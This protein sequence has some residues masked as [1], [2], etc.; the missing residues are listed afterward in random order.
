MKQGSRPDCLS[1]EQLSSLMEGRVE[2]QAHVDGCV[3]CQAELKML[4]EF[5]SGVVVA[6][7]GMQMQ[8]MRPVDGVEGSAV[9][10]SGGE[11]RVLPQGELNEVP[12]EWKWAPVAGAVR[13]EVKATEVD[14]TVLTSVE[15][16]TP[17]V[18]LPTALRAA[19]LPQRTILL[20]VRALDAGGRV[21]A[22]ADDVRMRLEPK[23][24]LQVK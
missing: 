22:Q 5:E 16:N 4:M 9:V 24:K 20:S 14:G 1:L 23:N 18:P 13:Y 3:F 11:I 19:M 8:S 15:V 21:V 12:V 2:H 17:S 10:R 7:I 6:A